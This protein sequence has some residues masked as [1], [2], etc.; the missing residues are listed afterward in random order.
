MKVAVLED[1]SNKLLEECI[2]TLFTSPEAD[3]V[4]AIV[5]SLI[6]LIKSRP[7]YAQLV[8]TS[9]TNWTPA[10]LPSRNAVQVKSVEKVVKL[11][12]QHLLKYVYRSSMGYSAPNELIKRAADRPPEPPSPLRLPLSSLSK[13]REWKKRRRRS[14][15]RPKSRPPEKDRPS[16]TSWRLNSRSGA[17]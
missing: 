4:S 10:A 7:Q 6:T 13:P 11:S 9:L 17:G 3:L 16:R 1:E 8:I 14:G 2:T 12:L 5:T 15:G